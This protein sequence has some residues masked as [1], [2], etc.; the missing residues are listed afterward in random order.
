MNQSMVLKVQLRVMIHLKKKVQYCHGRARRQIHP[1]KRYVYV[2]MIAYALSLTESI[3][4]SEPSTYK[5]VISSGEA[6]KWTDTINEKIESL[7]KNQTWELVKSPKGKKIV[8]CKL[9]F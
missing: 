1:S 2:D 5:E 7:H 4:I 9:V 8:G 6:V 3:E